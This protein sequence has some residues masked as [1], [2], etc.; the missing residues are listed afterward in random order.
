MKDVIKAL[1]AT[2]AIAVLS[3]CATIPDPKVFS[4]RKENVAT[5]PVKKVLVVIDLSLEF[6]S[7]A[8]GLVFSKDDNAKKMYEPIASAMV[9]EVRA[10]GG[11]AD[12]LLHTTRASL[13]IPTDYSHVWMQKLDRMTKTTST[14]GSWVSNRVWKATIGQR[15]TAAPEKFT[16]LF[17]SEY[18]ADSP[19][20]FMPP[21]IG[22]KEDCQKKYLAAVVQQWQKSGLK[23]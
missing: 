18:E 7:L 15:Q 22:N 6:D 14:A 9:K 21:L 10:S 12:Y 13:N 4:E 5:L 11:E 16:V 3:G 2:V 8:S 17:D 19:W 23:Q 20:C 1:C